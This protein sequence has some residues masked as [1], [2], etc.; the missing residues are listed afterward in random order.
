MINSEHTR[1]NVLKS[2]LNCVHPQLKCKYFAITYKG[3]HDLSS[4]D[5]HPISTYLQ[6][7]H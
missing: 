2:N 6:R 1:V 4:S 7:A 5:T 3:L